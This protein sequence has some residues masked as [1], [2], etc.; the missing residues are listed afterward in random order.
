MLFGLLEEFLW[1]VKQSQQFGLIPCFVWGILSWIR[2]G[3]KITKRFHQ[4]V[5]FIS[6][7]L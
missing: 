4:T 1:I 6:F 2:G 5:E 3:R 7:I